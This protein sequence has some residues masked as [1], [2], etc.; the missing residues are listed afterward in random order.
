MLAPACV[1]ALAQSP[2]PVPK[3][4]SM[5]TNAW[6]DLTRGTKKKTVI[7]RDCVSK[8]LL[9]QTYTKCAV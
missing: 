2:V 4:I 6:G 5:Y 7:A 9:L 1:Y 3:L 8:M